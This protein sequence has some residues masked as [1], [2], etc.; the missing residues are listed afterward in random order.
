ME[1]KKLSLTLNI[2][3]RSYPLKINPSEEEAVRNAEK[4]INQRI[5]QYRMTYGED[6]GLI[7]QDFVV[8][9][10]IQILVQNF[11]LKEKTDTKPM[12]D[13][14]KSLID[15]VDSYINN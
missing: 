10:A 8:M 3:G 5:N 4:T 11:S 12:E 9:T 15:K 14:I 13:K 1:E 7:P 2:D 6:S